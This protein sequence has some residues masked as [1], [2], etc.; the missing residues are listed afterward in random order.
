MLN[1]LA[2]KP[3]NPP[4]MRTACHETR[5]A[6]CAGAYAQLAR[7]ERSQGMEE[8]IDMAECDSSLTCGAHLSES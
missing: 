3:T 7:R 4:P 1:F 2:Q 8:M 5:L 6:V